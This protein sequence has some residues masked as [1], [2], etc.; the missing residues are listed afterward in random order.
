MAQRWMR[1]DI[2][3]STVHHRSERKLN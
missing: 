3:L 1:E 2:E